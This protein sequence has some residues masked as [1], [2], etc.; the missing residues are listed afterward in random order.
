MTDD[1]RT[2]VAR[3][4]AEKPAATPTS[5][6]RERREIFIFYTATAATQLYIIMSYSNKAML[7]EFEER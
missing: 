2:F 1:D 6:A 4:A 7:L 3:G 5:A